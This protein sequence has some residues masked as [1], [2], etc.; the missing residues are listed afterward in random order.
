MSLTPTH[1]LL[2]M[3][4]HRGDPPW[5]IRWRRGY[6]LCAGLLGL[7]VFLNGCSGKRL[8][9]NVLGDV[10]TGDAEIFASD[11]DP[12]L[13]REALPFGLKTLEGLLT[14]SPNHRGLLLSA[15]RGFTTY[16]YLLQEEADRWEEQDRSRARLLRTR[17]KRL[18]LRARGYSFRGLEL[19][20]P[21][22]EAT[23]RRDQ[24]SAVAQTTKDD[25]PFLYWAGVS[26]GG[27]LSAGVDDLALVP[28]APLFA[29]L[30]RRV[31]D[32]HERYEAGAAHEFLI[33]YEASRPG[34][35]ASLAREHFRRA[36]TLTNTPRASLFVALAEGLSI[37]EQNLDEF[38]AL[39]ERALAVDLDR[40]P[41]ERLINVTAQRRARWL[42]GRIPELFL[43]TDHKEVIP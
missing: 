2:A 25:A 9:A 24:D 29:V 21:Q 40:V 3:Q 4:T 11:D 1:T 12:E 37:R 38:N 32:I 10:L 36:L 5:G 6:A 17:V 18:Y 22:F 33:T 43:D 23:L 41:N 28:D 8:A 39:L 27:S 34:G 19:A 16:A 31:V 13:I 26:W 20:H 7:V 35:N 30:I 14:S 15:A 42:L